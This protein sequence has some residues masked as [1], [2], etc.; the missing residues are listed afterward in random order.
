MYGDISRA[1]F[2]FQFDYIKV[3]F[4]YVCAIY[5]HILETNL[6]VVYIYIKALNGLIKDLSFN[7]FSLN[8]FESYDFFFLSFFA[9]Y[10]E[11]YIKNVTREM[12]RKTYK[13]IP[14]SHIIFNSL[15]LLPVSFSSMKSRPSR[16]LCNFVDYKNRD[17]LVL[18]YC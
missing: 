13:S 16:A 3:K 10:N 8:Y 14:P 1:D 18:A 7:G 9:F 2:Y 6:I 15:T 4:S 17:F 11:N 5:F 12:I